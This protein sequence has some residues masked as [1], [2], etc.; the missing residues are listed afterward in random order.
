MGYE[1]AGA[2]GARMARPRGEV[3][4]F[5]GDGSYMM[6]NSDL[7]SSVLAGHKLTVVLCDNRGYACIER[8]QVGQG[9]A[10]FNNMLAPGQASVDWVAHA[11]AM[12]CRAERV[13]GLG[14]LEAALERA[15][16]ADRTSV[17]VIDTAPD[18]WSGGGAFWEVGVAEVSHRAEVAEAHTLMVEGRRRQR[19]GW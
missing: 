16:G 11:A 2:W 8:L 15:R 17:V 9:G 13:S 5:C 1:I 19:A 18:V 6:M 7:Y 3:I 12:G 4:S 14:E 10:S